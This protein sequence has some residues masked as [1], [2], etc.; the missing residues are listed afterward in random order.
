MGK[1]NKQ[2]VQEIE[3][4][5]LRIVT[6]GV[7]THGTSNNDSLAGT[8]ERD[9]LFGLG[10]QDTIDGGAG[11]D[12]ISGGDG[13]DQ[14][15]GGADMDIIDGGAGQDRLFG[16]QHTDIITGGGGDDTIAGGTGGDFVYGGDGQDLILWHPGD[17]DD[18][19]SGGNGD[20]T[21][22]LEDT[23]MS[24]EQILNAIQVLPGSPQP[25]LMDGYIDLK[26]VTGT[27]TIGQETIQF[28]ELE[29]LVVGGYQFYQ[30]RGEV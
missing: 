11:M 18:F 21:L 5:A 26:G 27:I 17:G 24:L 7:V 4:E 12:N 30:G 14:I 6:G 25:Q 23:G 22:R 19:I 2:V 9:L 20:D 10:G 8:D 13:D 1:T 15:R 3:A 16:N 28:R 29:R